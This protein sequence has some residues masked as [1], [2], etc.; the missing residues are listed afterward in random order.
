MLSL[1]RFISRMSLNESN[2]FI[3]KSIRYMPPSK[4]FIKLKENKPVLELYHK[5]RETDYNGNW[6]FNSIIKNGFMLSRHGNKGYGVYMANHGRYSYSWGGYDILGNNNV[7]IC[8]VIYDPQ[9]VFRYRSELVS[10]NFNSEYRITNPDL[11]YPKYFIEYNVEGKKTSYGWVD[12]G[13]FGC[14]KCDINK[15]RCDCP[16]DGYDE[17]DLV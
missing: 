7:I 11:I 9:D 16:L 1:N 13:N 14:P 6:D 4:N 3:I 10:P 12:H 17:F 15:T 5:T 2:K 8:E